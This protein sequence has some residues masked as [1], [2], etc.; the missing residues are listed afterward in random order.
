MW[1]KYKLLLSDLNY[2]KKRFFEYQL[3]TKAILTLLIWPFINLIMNSLMKWKGLS[4]VTNGLIT[5]FIF[6]PQGILAAISLSIIIL[7]VVL[8]ELGGLILIS[9]QV[10][11]REPATRYIPTLQHCL[12]KLPRLFGLEGLLIVLGVGVLFPL[13]NIGGNT[14]LIT[15]LQIPGFVQDVISASMLYSAIQIGVIILVAYL[16]LR[17]LFSLHFIMLENK[18]A[19]ASFKDSAR[20]IRKH[21]KPFFKEAIGITLIDLLIQ[22]IIIGFV[23][24]VFLGILAFVNIPPEIMDFVVVTLLFIGI[25]IWIAV[26]FLMTPI[27]TLHLTR[28][29][30]DNREPDVEL[31]DVNIKSVPDHRFIDKI[32]FRRKNIILLI[33]AT[34]VGASLMSYSIIYE[35]E[36]QKYDVKIT[37][38]RG[39][40][41]YAPENTI[42]ALTTAASN[43]ADYA[44]IDV[45]QTK[46]HQ[47]VLTHDTSLKRTT[48]VNKNVWELSLSEI[49]ELDAGSWFGDAFIG[50]QIP[51]LE[52]AI[53][54]S[55]GKI[56]LNIEIKINGHEK[57]IV[58]K[59]IDEIY[60]QGIEK[61]C[62]VTS[63]DYDVI[64]EVE[65]LAP[66][67]KTGYIM[68]VALGD[69][70]KLNVDF[71]SV[72]E[73][74][75]NEKFVV[76]AHLLGR[77][78]HVWTINE[79]DDMEKLIGLG[80]DNIITDN[81]ILL[82]QKLTTSSDNSD[83]LRI[84][85]N[86][87]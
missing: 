63:L 28:F 34:I 45:Q 30:L 57:D 85:D 79:G 25:A 59:V 21:L 54:S 38:H 82:K 74:N 37:A 55:K 80:V 68:F 22:M 70:S 84:L 17:Y 61:V 83:I 14:S 13:I 48:G 15:D 36:D 86:F 35:F 46:D 66:Q 65:R 56:K 43:G 9:Y 2:G 3:I 60:A 5:K 18:R 33:I 10:I 42:A 81:E 75:V 58:Q 53:Q 72:E 27:G 40:V 67:L 41:M 31:V 71:Y 50:E 7:F 87:L 20:L 32:V 77:E 51:T 64:Q 12:T 52:E 69:L 11:N 24:I 19:R 47:L 62:V 78:V 76:S 44:E 4:F 49:K 26:S 29:F 23:I 1:K 6:S 73:L 16:A 8:I 39:N